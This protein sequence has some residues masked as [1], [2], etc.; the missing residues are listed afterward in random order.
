[1]KFNPSPEEILAPQ[2]LLP[3]TVLTWKYLTPEHLAT[4]GIYTTKDSEKLRDHIMFPAEKPALLNILARGA[5]GHSLHSGSLSMYNLLDEDFLNKIV[6]TTTSCVWNGFI[7]F[8]SAT[9]GV[10]GIFVIIRIINLI[11]DTAIH[12]YALHSLYGCSLHLLRAV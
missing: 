8:G 5:G 3:M 9:A 1:M 12:G 6:D 7:T 11:I 4:S 10:F 2:Q